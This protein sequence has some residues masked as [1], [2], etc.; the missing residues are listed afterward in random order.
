MTTFSVLLERV[1]QLPVT[2]R[3]LKEVALRTKLHVKSTQIAQTSAKAARFPHMEQ[4]DLPMIKKKSRI[5]LDPD[6]EADHP[7]NF[8]K[9]SVYHCRAILKILLKSVDNV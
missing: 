4:P 2:P 3:A 7:Q 8:I 6:G 5:H 1:V 9:C